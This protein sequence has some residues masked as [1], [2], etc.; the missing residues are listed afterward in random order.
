M[1]DHDRPQERGVEACPACRGVGALIQ[2]IRM[3]PMIQQ[4]QQQCDK[5]GGRGQNIRHQVK[6][7]ETLEVHSRKGAEGAGYAQPYARPPPPG[8]WRLPQHSRPAGRW[9]DPY[10]YDRG[11]PS[12][13]SY[14]HVQHGGQGCN[15][16][17]EYGG[18]GRAV[19]DF[20]RPSPHPPLCP[21]PPR[22]SPHP[23][24]RTHPP[25]SQS[26][27]QRVAVEPRVPAPKPIPPKSRA[28]EPGD[29]PTHDP[30]KTRRDGDAGDS[31][32]P[33]VVVK[34][35]G[36]AAEAQAL[37][38]GAKALGVSRL[39]V[40]PGSKA[41]PLC[42][43]CRKQS[44]TPRAWLNHFVAKLKSQYQAERDAHEVWKRRNLPLL[45]AM[46]R[47]LGF[48][49]RMALA[50]IEAQ[51][52]PGDLEQYVRLVGLALKS[53]GADDAPGGEGGNAFQRKAREVQ[54]AQ[55]RIDDERK[56]EEEKEK[57]KE[58]ARIKKEEKAREEQRKGRIDALCAER[59]RRT[60]ATVRPC[61][62]RFESSRL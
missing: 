18:R 53:G 48:V 30:K 4:V 22:P 14:E 45:A 24:P 5:C 32:K 11:G 26:H 1:S 40:L 62:G 3:G 61:P 23:P 58:E 29:E 54:K 7:T 19:Y 50:N 37:A 60:A 38:R 52:S 59:E 57:E 55:A 49:G 10:P 36:V 21:H 51:V 41:S 8:A 13:A 9:N 42:P 56:E 15:Q 47:H 43:A 27:Q 2:T 6:V 39:I 33:A 20:C 44:K 35:P 31:A 25:H 46:M 16:G 12:G 28:R 34:A 17:Y